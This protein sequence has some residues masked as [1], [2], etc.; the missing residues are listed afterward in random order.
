MGILSTGDE[1][2]LPGEPIPAGGIVSSNTH[3]LAALIRGAGAEPVAL[4]IAQ[5]SFDALADVG[6][7]IEKTD[8]L[9]TSGGA[10][11]GEHDL[12]REA[13]QAQGMRLDF[14]TVAMRPG[15]PLMHGDLRGVPVIGL[16]GNPVSVMVSGLMLVRPAIECLSGLPGDPP[17][18]VTA[19]LGAGVPEND[20]RADHLRAKLE[21]RADGILLATAFPRQDSALMRLMAEADALIL[22]PPYAPALP[23]G[24]AV[25]IVRLDALM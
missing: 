17:A 22:R 14:W 1:I 18:V 6:A 16:P 15:K 25:P 20:R 2:A 4:P 9:V 11:V 24:S 8:L 12:V 21:T 3:V 10:S 23:A 5:D 19:V 7:W 13:L